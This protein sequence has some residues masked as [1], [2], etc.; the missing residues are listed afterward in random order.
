MNDIHVY[1]IQTYEKNSH[2]YYYQI[3]T[4]EVCDAK[5]K[6][7]TCVISTRETIEG[8]KAKGQKKT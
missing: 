2:N 1:S 3:V 7:T 5:C 4:H 8:T 6:N